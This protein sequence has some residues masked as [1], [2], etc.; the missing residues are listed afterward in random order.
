MNNQGFQLIYRRRK[1][2]QDI[3]GI[4]GELVCA[5]QDMICFCFRATSSVMAS[6]RK[7]SVIDFGNDPF[8]CPYG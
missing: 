7:N 4:R 1:L 3:E 8:L 2:Q 5:V 6:P